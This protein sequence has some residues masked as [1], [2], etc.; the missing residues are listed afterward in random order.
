MAELLKITDFDAPEYVHPRPT[1][2]D[3][4]GDYVTLTVFVESGAG[5]AFRLDRKAAKDIGAG[6]VDAASGKLGPATK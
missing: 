4:P 6:L 2:T 1:A 3:D 5:F